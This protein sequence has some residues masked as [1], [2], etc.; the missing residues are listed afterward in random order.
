MKAYANNLLIGTMTP[1]G[2]AGT[3]VCDFVP[4]AVG[5]YSIF[6]IVTNEDG[7]EKMGSPRDL[8]ITSSTPVGIDTVKSDNSD[9]PAYNLMGVPVDAGYR[10]IV[11]K[12]GKKI[13]IK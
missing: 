13:V 9:G 6:A 11:I 1:T 12:N 8:N 3:Y 5:T 2:T 4:S 7:K 10:G